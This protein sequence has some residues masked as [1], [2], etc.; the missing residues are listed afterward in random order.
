[1]EKETK[2]Q[3]RYRIMGYGSLKEIEGTWEEIKV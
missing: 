3:R 2:K 1:M